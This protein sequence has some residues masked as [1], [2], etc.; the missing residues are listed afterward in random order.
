MET[1]TFSTLRTFHSFSCKS[2]SII[3]QSCPK[4]FIRFLCECLEKS[5]RRKPP[6][7]KQASSGKTLERSSVVSKKTG[8]KDRTF[9]PPKKNLQLLKVLV[10]PVFFSFVPI[11]SR[12]L[13]SLF[14]F[15]T[16]SVWI[17]S[18]LTRQELPNYQAEQNFTQQIDSLKR[19]LRK[20]SL[21]EQTLKLTIFFLVYVSSFQNP[22]R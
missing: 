19:K 2:K 20:Y 8:I 18:Q 15:I 16:T 22:N 14:F 11:R 5:A 3:L 13:S 12:L 1:Q 17:F 7:R 10:S 9:K 21:S 4:I 6:S